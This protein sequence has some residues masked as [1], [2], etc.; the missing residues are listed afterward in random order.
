MSKWYMI[1][2]LEDKTGIPHQTIRRY[3]E[4]HPQHLTI[5]KRHKSYLVLESSIEIIEQIRNLYSKGMNA[6]QVDEELNA[7]G[8]PIEYIINDEKSVITMGTA[9]EALQEGIRE[10]HE[11]HEKQEKFNK[12]LIE[13]LQQQEEYIKNNVQKR[14]QQLISSI[15]EQ[16]EIK[17]LL[18]EVKETQKQIAAANDEKAK[19]GWFTRLFNK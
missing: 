3:M 6:E 5:R 4:R 10:L 15:R 18:I 7:S 12:K 1:S 11:K 2:E 8:L 19:K 14:D 17:Q 9:F 13:K 16:Q